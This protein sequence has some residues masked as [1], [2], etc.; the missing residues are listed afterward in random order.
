[1]ISVFIK[2][3]LRDEYLY[4]CV[5]S[6]RKVYPKFKIFIVDDGLQD[7]KKD[8]FY[9]KLRKEGHKVWLFPFDCGLP[10]GRNFVANQIKS[11]YLLISDDDFFFTKISGIE[12]MAKI[13]DS[14]P[15]IGLV[16]GRVKENGEIK[17]YQGYIKRQKDG[18]I[19]TKLELK[20]Y[21]K[22]K[23][24][25]YKLCDITFNYALIRKEVFKKVLWDTNIKVAYEHSDFFLKVKDAGWDI[26]FTPDCVVIHKPKL[27][28][29]VHTQY[30]LYRN[31][32]NDRDYFF[33]KWKIK[34]T[35]DMNGY[36]DIYEN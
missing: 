15:N 17:N 11:K 27:K 12:K 33:K 28:K 1:M 3:F 21:K 16:G 36:K 32:K 24:V 4:K 19:Y 10:I 20:N 30:N 2:T 13:L 22:S 6:I 18:F 34:W 9:K 35:I 29:E 8:K 26:A 14:N 23:G 31:R 25:R 7:K 5:N